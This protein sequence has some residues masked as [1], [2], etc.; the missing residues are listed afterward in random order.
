MLSGERINKLLNQ[1]LWK[2][3][4]DW[5]YGGIAVA[6]VIYWLMMLE[7]GFGWSYWLELGMRVD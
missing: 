5:V 4:L 1:G 7:R 2:R 6:M 3:E